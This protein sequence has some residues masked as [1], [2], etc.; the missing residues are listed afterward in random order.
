MK[1]TKRSIFFF[2]A[3]FLIRKDIQA[4]RKTSFQGENFPLLQNS[5][6]FLLIPAELLQR[7]NKRNKKAGCCRESSNLLCC[8]KLLT[9]QDVFRSRVKD[10]AERCTQSYT[11]VLCRIV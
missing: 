5:Y 2:F 4:N 8:F 6:L 9:D 7:V 10:R 11:V 3:L 1:W